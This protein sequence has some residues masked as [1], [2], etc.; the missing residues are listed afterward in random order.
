MSGSRGG[1]PGWLPVSDSPYYLCGQKATL[2]K[3]ALNVI[4]K[5]ETINPLIAP[6]C[7]FSG[8]K[9][10]DIHACKH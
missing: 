2:D 8:L 5:F 1:R 7:K 4:R 9:G 6:A 10:A 3:R